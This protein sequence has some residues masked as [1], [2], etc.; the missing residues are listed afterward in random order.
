MLSAS[1]SYAIKV[2]LL[3]SATLIDDRVHSDFLIHGSS[4]SKI[5]V[6]GIV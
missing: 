4:C 2:L 6:Y 1:G 5:E 3:P